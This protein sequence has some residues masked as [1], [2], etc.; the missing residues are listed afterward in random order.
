MNQ[1]DLDLSIKNLSGGN[2][3][4]KRRLKLK[5]ECCRACQLFKNDEI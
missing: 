2:Q 3:V 5:K 4:F 1:E